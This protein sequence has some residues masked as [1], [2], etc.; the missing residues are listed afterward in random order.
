M[1]G[2]LSSYPAVLLLVLCPRGAAAIVDRSF[3]NAVVACGYSMLTRRGGASTVTR[4]RRDE[5]SSLL[6]KLAL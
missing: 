1:W 6:F 4:F 3:F 5:G 2:R